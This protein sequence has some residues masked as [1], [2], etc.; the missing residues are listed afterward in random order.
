MSQPSSPRLPRYA[1]PWLSY[2]D[3]VAR[4]ITRGLS[5]PDEAVAERF[6]AHRQLLPSQ[7]LLL[8]V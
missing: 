2:P 5:V 6:L 1:K 7:R 3:Q 8:G 4:L